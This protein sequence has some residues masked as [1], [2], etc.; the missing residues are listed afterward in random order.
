MEKL[1]LNICFFLDPSRK[2]KCSQFLNEILS[3]I[4][5][6]VNSKLFFII[7][8]LFILIL[9]KLIF[10]KYNY[11]YNNYVISTLIFFL[12]CLILYNFNTNLPWVD[13]WEWIENLQTEK[14]DIIIWLFQP[15]NIHNIFFV[16]LIFLIN[17]NFFNLNFELFNYLSIILIFFITLIFLKNEKI[18][19]KIYLSL[20][21]VLIFSG[22]QFANFS[23]AS[24]IAWTICFF[25]I[26]SF[27][28]LF[29]SKTALSIICCSI[30]TFISPLTFGLGYVLPLFVLSFVYFFD[31]RSKVKII[32][33]I[34]SLAGVLISYLLPKIIFND[35]VG[36]TLDLNN[37]KVLLDFSF[38]STFFGVLANIYL[39]WIEGFA[40]AGTLIGF[41]QFLIIFLIEFKK[42][43]Q[44]IFLTI[45]N[46]I[47][48]NMFIILGLIF[49][50]IV[51]IARSD[52]QTIVAAR[53]SVGSII[54]QIGFWLF[55]YNEMQNY[56]IKNINLIKIISLYI[57][58][59][60]LL[61]PYHGIHWQAKRHILNNIVLD[62]FKKN[63]KNETLICDKLAYDTLFY[64]GNWY[65]YDVFSKQIKILKNEKKS[66]LNF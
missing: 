39:P 22:K 40:Y 6:I 55:V 10:Q 52:T 2:D 16:K 13:D 7:L 26:I 19:N 65:D 18:D 11:K 62:C 32:Y 61:F 56:Y 24:N 4:G 31:L 53:Y 27:K 33:I 36:N 1:L 46:F 49:A 58:L 28:Y 8:T 29:E 23:Q 45:T 20:F 14:L 25:Y 64:G 38:Y 48:K 60:G 17:N 21:V 3:T 50:F 44:N 5:Y 47:K 35:L 43:N 34:F 57:F 66:F 51:S 9:I 37:L 54:F 30:L 15:T 63:L 41:L 42:I 12:F 59:S